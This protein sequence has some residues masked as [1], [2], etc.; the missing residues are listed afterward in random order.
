MYLDSIFTV[1]SSISAAGHGVA[2]TGR[3]GVFSVLRD[4]YALRRLFKLEI[5]NQLNTVLIRF[6]VLERALSLAS[7]PV[8]KGA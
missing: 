1:V 2:R 7:E 5:L 3:H 4:L 6:V 8:W